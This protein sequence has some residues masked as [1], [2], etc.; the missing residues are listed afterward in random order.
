MILLRKT[1]EKIK[2][3]SDEEDGQ[4]SI[5][6]RWKTDAEIMPPPPI[7]KKSTSI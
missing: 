6:K 5:K 7:P 4:Q 2:W 1:Q 3:D